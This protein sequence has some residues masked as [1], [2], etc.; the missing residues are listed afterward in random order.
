M[1]ILY[2]SSRDCWPPNTGARIRDYYLAREMGRQASVT[3]FG[4]PN[5]DDG[6]DPT[7]PPPE[8]SGIQEMVLVPKQARYTPW[9]LL[10]G[11]W[12]PKP[13]TVLNCETLRGRQE[14][15]RVLDTR[16]FDTVQ[17]EGVHLIGYLPILRAAS[18]RPRVIC[19]WHNIESEIMRRYSETVPSAARR[20]YARRT[21]LLLERAEDRLLQNCDA[22]VVV[23]ERERQKLLARVPEARIQVVG[24]GVDTAYFS[25][26][27]GEAAAEPTDVVFVGSMN[28]HANIDAAVWMAQEVWP[29]VRRRNPALRLC[30][31]GCDP[32]PEVRALGALEGVVVTGTVGDLRPYYGRALAAVAPLRSGS[33]TRL[34][35][36]EAMA[37]G[38]AVV[39]TALGAEGLEVEAGR[40]FVMAGS[41]AGMSQAVLDLARDAAARQRL[42]A[43]GR[44]V[45]ESLYDWSALARTLY[46]IHCQV[47][48]RAV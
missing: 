29:E 22:H 42:I 47:A 23:S 2:F 7:P 36:L 24:N 14:L 38:V 34:K 31:V 30:L 33:G 15:A 32:A 11:L 26:V 16:R 5:S 13:V 6:R 17:M 18:N 44:K 41:A 1:R 4:L 37:A 3:Y 39:S 27:A 12:G 43:A 21:A 9:K 45:V 35:I 10:R 25:T 19:D 28:Y 46:G 8:V 40:D 20:W 48:G